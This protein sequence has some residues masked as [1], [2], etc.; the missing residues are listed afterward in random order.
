MCKYLA[1]S[2][3][4]LV[5]GT[6]V[7]ELGSGVGFCGLFVAA[8]GA[9]EVVLTDYTPDLL[10]TLRVNCSLMAEFL[11]SCAGRLRVCWLDWGDEQQ[12]RVASAGES[13]TSTASPLTSL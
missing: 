8:M 10:D 4:E 12:A 9:A 3:R 7:L 1:E 13:V 5:M 6:R 11:P 2:N